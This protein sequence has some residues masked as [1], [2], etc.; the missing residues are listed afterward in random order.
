MLKLVKYTLNILIL[1]LSINGVYAKNDYMFKIH[2]PYD[3][4]KAIMA[5]P[6]AGIWPSDPLEP[7]PEPNLSLND[8]GEVN[9][10]TAYACDVK[11]G[12]IG[13]K[14]LQ[15]VFNL[16]IP[17]ISGKLSHKC[18]ATLISQQ[19]LITSGHCVVDI[20]S[21]VPGS[22][23][24]SLGSF[25]IIV[26]PGGINPQSYVVKA[27]YLPYHYDYYDEIDKSPYF[28]YIKEDFALLQLKDPL[29][30]NFKPV[31][32]AQ[33]PL[34][35]NGPIE[36]WM[37]GYG[38]NENQVL[39]GQLHFRKQYYMTNTYDSS[40]DGGVSGNYGQI[41]TLGSIPEK[42]KG[43]DSAWSFNGPGDSGG[44]ILLVNNIS[45]QLYLEGVYTGTLNCAYTGFF[46]RLPFSYSF[47]ISVPYY[48]DLIT[49]VMAGNA[50]RAATRCISPFGECALDKAVYVTNYNHDNISIKNINPDTAV[51]VSLGKPVLT[52]RNPGKIIF[53]NRGFFA[54]VLN[55]GSNT[56]STYQVRQDGYLVASLPRDSA[57]DAGG[58]LIDIAYNNGY[59]YVADY[60]SNS[61][62][63]YKT[64]TDGKL[65][66]IQKFIIH[67][68]QSQAVS[69]TFNHNGSYAYITSLAY[70]VLVYEVLP[71]GQLKYLRI[72]EDSNFASAF[73]FNRQVGGFKEAAYVLSSIA[74]TV[75]VYLKET[76]GA[77]HLV[78]RIMLNDN[79]AD[80]EISADNSYVYV[81][82]VA[83][84]RITIFRIYPDGWLDDIGAVATGYTTG[85]MVISPS[86]RHLLLTNPEEDTVSAY[87]VLQQVS[88]LEPAH[89]FSSGGYTP[90][91][92]A[93][94]PKWLH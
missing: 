72:L 11:A 36:V 34:P 13:G 91:V 52:G 78:Q 85:G 60:F 43:V 28:N 65:A 5:C 15:S 94:L 74:K 26:K 12:N 64:D 76:D 44:P 92:I 46:A 33:V 82:H 19:W 48:Y 53:D 58:Q 4:Q 81:T 40:W 80:I 29:P 49:S 8:C 59:I 62:F 39:D 3:P 79:P 93:T 16:E 25:P 42:Y 73:K 63:V 70:G 51:A 55:F 9:A 20:N 88:W 31:S 21:S 38:L 77:L 22:F 84:K 57:I 56:I 69:I 67:L 32:L 30:I 1:F 10:Q 75:S 83:S 6:N 18:T 89:K 7:L 61:I 14:L 27:V 86:G 45:G 50:P 54:Y 35:Q 68:P 87:K 90:I 47:N 71:D 37:A 41:Y 2:S 23:E 66:F 17:D 24:P